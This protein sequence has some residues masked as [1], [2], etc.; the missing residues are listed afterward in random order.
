MQQYEVQILRDV[1][2]DRVE[3]DLASPLAPEDFAGTL[4][5][6]LGL[7]G[8]ALPLISNAV[9]EE[10]SQHK[11]AVMEQYLVGSGALYL[12]VKRELDQAIIEEREERIEFAASKKRV[13]LFGLAT[14]DG[15]SSQAATPTPGPSGIDSPALPPA[16]I[17]EKRGRGRP[18]KYPR[19]SGVDDLYQPAVPLLPAARRRK[20]AEASMTAILNRTAKPLQDI[21]RDWADAKESGPFLERLNADDLERMAHEQLRTARRGKRDQA[22]AAPGRRRR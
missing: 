9:R 14:P 10:L 17:T 20:E 12:H 6:D 21:W 16:A 15:P 19:T 2:R 8:E 13:E 11:R 3:W 4:C 22:R 1:L 7:S 18:P 5:Q